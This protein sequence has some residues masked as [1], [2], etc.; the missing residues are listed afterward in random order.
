MNYTTYLFDFDYT[1]ADSS[2][3]IVTC[4]RN[5]LTRHGYT[6]ITDETI[7]RTI[8]KTLEDSFAILTGVT[9]KEQLISFRKEYS[10][11]SEIYMNANTFF[12]PDTLPTLTALKAQGAR[13]GIIST[14]YRHVITS[15]LN[16]HLPDGWFDLII[17]AE[18]VKHHKPAPEG[19][20]A[21]VARL[22][23]DLSETLYIGDSTIDAETALNAGIDFAGVTT[24]TTERE[25]LEVFPHK[26]VIGSLSEL[27]PIP[28]NARPAQTGNPDRCKT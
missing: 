24:G 25:E 14:K 10:A 5:V 20:L 9:D 15:F 12:F 23:A 22:N 18:D 26:M 21:A 2:K 16:E 19:L 4:F 8:G 3:G 13:I 6:G 11:E 28:N 17:G 1:L 27:T 7:K